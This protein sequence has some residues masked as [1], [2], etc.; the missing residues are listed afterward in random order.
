MA[1]IPFERKYLSQ[2]EL[3]VKILPA[4][5]LDAT[6]ALKGGTAINLFERPLPRLSVDIDLCYPLFSR[7]QQAL[8]LVK[9]A[10]ENIALL[11]S[12]QLP[13]I[14]IDQSQALAGEC[15]LF[16][17]NQSAIVK[18][19]V[20][21]TGR[22][23]VLPLR[24]M[25][26]HSRVQELVGGYVE[27]SVISRAELYGGKICAAL[28]RQHP[29]D[30]FDVNLLLRDH[31]LERQVLLGFI[32]SLIGH[33]RPISELLDPHRLEMQEAFNRQFA[34]MSE[35]SFTYQDYLNT[36]EQLI[37]LIHDSLSKSDRQFLLSIKNGE[38]DWDLLGIEN[39]SKLPA[40]LWKLKNIRLLKKTS[41]AKHAQQLNRLKEVLRG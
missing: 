12:R 7:R 21:T 2:L 41:P 20:N 9:N 15:K 30:L 11:L 26:L 34:G 31:G 39:V 27:M 8:G 29:R 32:I 22:G 35:I 36:K 6:F 1:T 24:V 40:V 13:N 14:K 19:E 10:L 5:S 38:P 23:H 37:F 3:L 17:K 4:I 18:I 28:D 25:P 33:N 16:C